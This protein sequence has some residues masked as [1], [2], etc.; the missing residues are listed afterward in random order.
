M[1][2][3]L[4]RKVASLSVVQVHIISGTVSLVIGIWCIHTAFT[5][6]KDFS[7]YLEWILVYFN[8]LF[9]LYHYGSVYKK[10]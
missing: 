2:E 9:F 7:S 3:K 4:K 10:K 8:L 1:L 5:V 6:E